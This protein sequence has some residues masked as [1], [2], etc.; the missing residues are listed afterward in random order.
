MQM[1]I[2][3]LFLTNLNKNTM[4]ANKSDEKNSLVSLKIRIS[5]G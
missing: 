1:Y 4:S 2:N 5:D 3:F